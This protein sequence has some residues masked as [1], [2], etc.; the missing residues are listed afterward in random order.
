MLQAFRLLALSIP[1][2]ITN[3]RLARLL[4]AHQRFGLINALAIPMGCSRLP[5]AAGSTV[6]EEPVPVVGVWLRG[7]SPRGPRTC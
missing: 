4:E 5:A 2:V 7:E 1:F 3:R 6:F